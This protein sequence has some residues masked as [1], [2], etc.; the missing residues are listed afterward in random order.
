MEN[1]HLE[2]LQ[3]G[4]VRIKDISFSLHEERLSQDPSKIIKI[5]FQNIFGFNISTNILNLTLRVYFH[6]EDESPEF[7]LVDTSVQNLFLVE[8]LK[9]YQINDSVLDL[10]IDFLKTLVSLTISHTRAITSK[11]LAGTAMQGLFLPIVNLEEVTKNFFP[12]KFRE[13]TATK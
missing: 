6:Y 1:Q 5:E 3:F 7:T 10:P 11:N 13:T 12:E 2:P 8:N 9:I 4:M